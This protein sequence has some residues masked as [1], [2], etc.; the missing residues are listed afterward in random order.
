MTYVAA[1]DTRSREAIVS[2]QTLQASGVLKRAFWHTPRRTLGAA[3]TT[4]TGDV[5]D[6]V[7]GAVAELEKRYEELP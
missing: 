6:G 2:P 4:P 7:P 3:G 5:A 1:N